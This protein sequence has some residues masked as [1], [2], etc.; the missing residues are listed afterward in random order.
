[1]LIII[2]AATQSSGGEGDNDWLTP[3]PGSPL[4]SLCS[5]CVEW[6]LISGSMR[7][8]LGAVSHPATLLSAACQY[9]AA[10][11]QGGG[12]GRARQ[13]ERQREIQRPKERVMETERQR[14]RERETSEDNESERREGGGQSRP[15]NGSSA[16]HTALLSPPTKACG[17]WEL[18]LLDTRPLILGPGPLPLLWFPGMCQ[19]HAHSHW[20]A[21]SG[22]NLLDTV[23][24][25]T[26]QTIIM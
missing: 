15:E 21:A 9:T 6:P 26:G 25:W 24:K 5:V 13:G 22:G 7:D 11:A 1:M 4:P 3:D 12:E 8:L 19:R 20:Q 2:R 23:F 10:C 14:V 18:M 16:R 17:L